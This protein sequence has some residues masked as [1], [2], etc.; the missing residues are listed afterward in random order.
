M[1]RLL[2]PC[3]SALGALFVTAIALTSA[4]APASAQTCAEGRVSSAETAGRCCWPGQIWS[5]ASRS[6]EGTPS[7]PAP[8]V[9]H[10]D[11][12][13][14]PMLA[15]SPASPPPTVAAP[16]ATARPRTREPVYVP[17][18]EATAEL[19][20]LPSGNEPRP[21]FIA[22]G[23]T[24]ILVSW[25]VSATI[26]P[27]L[28]IFGLGEPA[29]FYMLQLVPVLGPLLAPF[30]ADEGARNFWWVYGALG[31]S[32]QITAWIILAVGLLERDADRPRELTVRLQG[33]G[34][35]I[36]F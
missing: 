25:T 12:C 28:A 8:W 22:Y 9:A 14:P 35:G 10:G 33:N 19:A 5:G 34:I 32:L 20:L 26:A 21:R 23:T 36:T 15:P 3:S 31:S 6:C 13:A 17:S 4:P 11:G 29:G 27:M 16:A 1:L 18:P 30:A 24:G 2:F 7:C